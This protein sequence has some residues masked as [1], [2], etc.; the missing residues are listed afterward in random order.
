MSSVSGEQRADSAPTVS[1]RRS[2]SSSSAKWMI[3]VL[4]AGVILPTAAIGLELLFG[5]CQWLFNVIP[6]GWHLLL[7]AL[8]PVSNLMTLAVYKRPEFRPVVPLSFLVGASAGT[9]LI[10]SVQFL[11]LIPLSAIGILMM[12]LGLLGFSPFL[13]LAS[14]IVC[15]RKLGDAWF[16][17]GRR[18]TLSVWAGLAVALLVLGVFIFT[19]WVTIKGLRMA[20]SPDEKTSLRG[21]K[22]IRTLG[23]NATLLRA[24]YELPTE[25]WA[26]VIWERNWENRISRD[27]ARAVYYRVTGDSFNSVPAPR[28]VG[29]RSRLV[30]DADFDSDV[31]G[32]AVNGV[33]RN[34][35]MASSRIDA[36]VDPT[37]LTA[38]TEWTLVF[39]NASSEQREARAE[40]ALPHG[41]VVSRLTLWINGEPREAAF[42][43][44]GVVREA[45]QQVAVVQRRDPVLVTTCGPDRVL[46]QCFPVPPNGGTMKV[47]LGITSP[48]EPESDTRALY[49]LPRFVERNFG[50]AEETRH[51]VFVESP[52]GITVVGSESPGSRVLRETIPDADLSKKSTI[53]CSRAATTEVW[54]PDPTAPKDYAVVQFV[55]RV[56]PE[57]PA[58]L[59]VL[60]DGSRRLTDNR[61]E[62]ARALGNIPRGCGLAVLKA[63]DEIEELVSGRPATPDAIR[64]AQ[65]SIRR[66]RCAGGIDN[67]PALLRAFDAAADAPGSMILW[68]H[69][70]QPFE[71]SASTEQLLQVVERRPGFIRMVAVAADD[72]RNNVLSELERTGAV[73][74]LDRHGS[75]S[76]DLRRLFESWGGKSGGCLQV[77]RI[78]VPFANASGTKVSSHLAKL[79]ARDEVMRMCALND[80][81]K[82][83]DAAA[84]ATAYQVV[85][86]ASGAVVLENEEQYEQAKLK[87][88]NPKSVPSIVPEPASWVALALGTGLLAA[89]ARRGKPLWLQAALR[90][91]MEPGS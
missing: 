84:L 75:L 42:G 27:Q 10:Y 17:E 36:V 76:E 78:R 7:L 41:G 38:Y 14:S 37:A 26:G 23:S 25:P 73:S 9:A 67:R 85:T 45:Y 44:R 65:A 13:A 29:P 51:S 89:R 16:L 15:S 50:V 83:P 56:R 18:R 54:T 3:F 74:V 71:P 32:T 1:S 80:S 64:E 11:P 30:G 43:P 91:P 39:T 52:Q 47:R 69:G 72:G 68:I 48:L 21:V 40:V 22:L 35:S 6:T 4:I 31:G 33:V 82:L 55:E 57:T 19:D 2:T 88:A 53:V 59:V 34:L 60:I 66:M 79:W 46:V 81:R 86:P 77:R 62:I 28:L 61:E 90:R 87:P 70:P 20:V 58:H 24:C 8:V 63:G 49:T 5:F 12:G